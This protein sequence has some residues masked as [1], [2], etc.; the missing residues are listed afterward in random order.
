MELYDILVFCSIYS[1]IVIYSLWLT[2]N[3]HLG[4]QISSSASNFESTYESN[5]ELN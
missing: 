5:F 2:L 1:G 3:D 4:A